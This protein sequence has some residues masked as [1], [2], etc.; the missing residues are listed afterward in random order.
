MKFMK[1]KYIPFTDLDQYDDFIVVDGLHPKGLILSHWRGANI[2][3]SIWA[4]T[5]GEIVLNAIQQKFEGVDRPNISATHFDID[6]FVGVWALFE[7]ELAMEYDEVLRRVAII[8]DFRHFNPNDQYDIEAL[9]LVCWINAVEEQ[10]FYV[11]FGSDSELDD[12]VEKF[13]YFLARF[14]EVLL[15]PDAFQSI[16]EPEFDRV[17]EDCSADYLHRAYPKLGLWLNE[18]AVPRHYYALFGPTAAYDMVLNLYDENRYELEFKYT[19]WVD[20]VSR[21]TFPRLNMQPLVDELNA[22]E[23]SDYHWFCDKITDTGPI[24]RLEDQRLSKAVRYA[25]PYQREIYSSS[26]PPKQF[27]A[28]VLNYLAKAYEKTSAKRFWTWKEL[29]ALSRT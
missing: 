24:L 3:P 15:D 23:K 8:G 21:P 7:P 28:M 9:K 20:L 1:K 4:D 18:T 25:Q 17:M 29:R 6:G 16:W 26:I 14:K 10:E 5:S 11:P 27:E 13:D 22:I 12:C 19:T 2:Y